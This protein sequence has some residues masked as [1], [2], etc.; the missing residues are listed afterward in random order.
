MTTGGESMTCD[1]WSKMMKVKIMLEDAKQLGFKELQMLLDGIMREYERRLNEHPCY[2][3]SSRRW[4]V[5]LEV[6][7]VSN[8]EE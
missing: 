1:N 2:K 8:S 6:K 5:E 4:K 7:T 3:F